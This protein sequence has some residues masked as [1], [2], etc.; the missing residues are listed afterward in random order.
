M[1]FSSI[2]SEDYSRGARGPLE[3]P[4]ES[5]TFIVPFSRTFLVL[6]VDAHSWKN[7]RTSATFCRSITPRKHLKSIWPDGKDRGIFTILTFFIV[8]V[9][10]TLATARFTVHTPKFPQLQPCF[11]WK[12]YSFRSQKSPCIRKHY[13][14]R[15]KTSTFCKKRGL[16]RIS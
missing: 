10:G 3:K 8:F 4:R 2:L 9:H 7:V 15:W 14:L 13:S 16:H 11:V 6:F 5:G 12:V 1:L